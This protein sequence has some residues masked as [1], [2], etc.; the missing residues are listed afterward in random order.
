M[1]NQNPEL[2]IELKDNS[3]LTHS[4]ERLKAY[5][6]KIIKNGGKNNE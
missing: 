3:S 1:T 2:Q 5:A 6:K 4:I